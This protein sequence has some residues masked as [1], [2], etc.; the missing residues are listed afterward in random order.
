MI[1]ARLASTIRTEHRPSPIFANHNRPH[2]DQI[3]QVWRPL[4]G[5]NVGMI[6]GS[7]GASQGGAQGPENPFVN[8]Y[9]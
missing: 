5:I 1:P 8:L 2:I 9:L 7:L 3:G 4:E 6:W